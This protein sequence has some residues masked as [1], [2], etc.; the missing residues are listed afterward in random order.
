MSK[1]LVLCLMGPTASGKTSLAIDLA[2]QLNGE[3]VSVDSALIYKD[4]DIGTAK[5]T[6]SEQDGIPHHLIDICSPEHS[7]SVADFVGDVT[8]IIDSLHARNKMPILAGGTMMYFNALVNGINQ[9]PATDQSVREQV[10]QMPLDEV[11][12]QL[13]QHDP[14]TAERLHASDTQRL[15]RALEVYL[16]TG[17]PL[18]EWQQQ[19]K[20]TFPYSFFQCAILPTKREILHQQIELRFDQMLRQGLIEE[21]ETLLK[22]YQLDPDMPSMRSVGYRQVWQ[23]LRG[24][25]CRDEM[26]ERGIIATRQLAKRQLTWLRSW[27]E[28]LTL[29]SGNLQNLQRVIEKM[30]ARA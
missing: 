1:P 5:P 11:Y 13:Q 7:Y 27:P 22:K 30:G 12:Q 6:L 3:V 9:L 17:K 19:Q 15:G 25:Y 18:S 20:L 24:E 14:A 2:K 4:M 28:L 26:R 16:A 10:K 8:K 21:V 23:Y 29:E